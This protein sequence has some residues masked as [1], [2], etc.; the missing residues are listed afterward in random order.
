MKL[1]LIYVKWIDAMADDNTWK[2][3]SDAIDWGGNVPCEIDE[4]GYLIDEDEEYLLLASKINNNLVTG[5]MRIPIKYIIEQKRQ[6]IPFNS[7]PNIK[8]Q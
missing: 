7:K 8:K 3:I 4:V 2:T 5:L 1:E 6:K